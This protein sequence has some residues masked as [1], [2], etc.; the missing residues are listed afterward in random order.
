ML[1]A[2]KRLYTTADRD[3]FTGFF[4]KKEKKRRV[5]RPKKKKRRY[6]KK[7]K[8]KKKQTSTV[9]QTLTGEQQ[10]K[11]KPNACRQLFADEI[12]GEAIKAKRATKAKRI[13]W[14]KEP[15]SSYRARLATS[16]MTQTDRWVVGESFFRFC[17]RNGIDRNVLQNYIQRIKDAGPNRKPGGKKRGRKPTLPPTVMHHLC[18]GL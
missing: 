17:K 13:N 6:N 12:E 10:K 4:T 16:W 11:P 15:H 7:K 18:E 5:G 8:S 9:Q 2:K 1:T 3:R 14:D